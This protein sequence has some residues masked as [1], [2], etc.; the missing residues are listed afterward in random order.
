MIPV[1]EVYPYLIV[2]CEPWDSDQ[3]MRA[4]VKEIH[5]KHG[6]NVGTGT[7]FYIFVDTFDQKKAPIKPLH[8]NAC[9]HPGQPCSGSGQLCSPF[10]VHAHVM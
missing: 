8:Q 2:G 4:H 1:W 6:K 3:I 10:H 5:G 9:L 7:V